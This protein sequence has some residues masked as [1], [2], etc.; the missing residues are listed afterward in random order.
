MVMDETGIGAELVT[1]RLGG[2][3]LRTI[4]G[5]SNDWCAMA[6]TFLV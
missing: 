1:L 2:A 6:A 4:N 5:A 3:V